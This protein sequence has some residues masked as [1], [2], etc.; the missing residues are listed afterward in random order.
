M[1]VVVIL[2]AGPAAVICA[3][4]VQR[5]GYQVTVVSE[6]RRFSAVEGVSLRVL[7][8]LQ[9]AGLSS[10]LEAVEQACVRSVLW[11]GEYNE[12][13]HEYLLDRPRFDQALR[14]QLQDAG[15]PLVTQR[16]LRV[17]S[18]EHRHQVQLGNGQIL[19]ADFLIE[20]RGRQA[21]GSGKKMRGP[22]TLSL[23]NRWQGPPQSVK[24]ALHSHSDGWSWMA[25]LADGRCYWQLTLDVASA[26]LPSKAR[27]LEYCR[28]RRQAS[29]F[30]QD[31]FQQ[32]EVQDIDLHA[33]SSSSTLSL[34]SCGSNWLRIGDAAMAVDPL[35]GNGVFQALSSA[36]QAPAV[37]YTLLEKPQDAP[38]AKEFHQ[39]RI[40]HLFLRFARLGRD[41][42][43]MEQQWPDQP[44]W[45]ARQQ[46]PDQQPMHNEPNFSQLKLAHR[47]VIEN[48]QIVSREVVISPDQP[49]GMWHHSGIALAPMLR[50]L[51]EQGL[52]NLL[53]QHSVIEQGYIKSWLSHQGYFADS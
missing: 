46:W 22:E 31:F 9:H 44:F 1:P 4:G 39:Q 33:R 10:V 12:Q 26:Q 14:Q 25:Q 24:T 15:I 7:E 27:L 28:Q 11:N 13:N 52:S 3:L 8:S 42:Y 16:V 21:P 49:L 53:G 18:T 45:Q 23:L 19:T 43:Q 51:R 2:G 50:Q 48:G 34:D 30:A 32:S 36:L 17:H 5:L 47:P 6:A 35:S 20:A 41:F 38:L 40:E 29:T 37:L